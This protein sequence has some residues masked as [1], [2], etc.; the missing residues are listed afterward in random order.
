MTT[1]VKAAPRGAG[2]GLAKLRVLVIL[3]DPAALGEPAIR[4]EIAALEAGHEVAV[5]TRSA[6]APKADPDTEFARVLAE[7]AAFAPEVLHAHGLGQSGFVTRLAAAADLPFTLRAHARDCAPLRPPR[8]GER[9]L[10][11]LRR[12]PAPPPSQDLAAALRATADERC[13]GLLALPFARPWLLRAGVVEGKLVDC[14]PALDFAAFHDLS[15]NGEAVMHIGAGGGSKPVPDILRLAAKVP[16]RSFTHYGEVNA[17]RAMQLAA[18]LAIAGPVAPEAMPAEYKKHRWLVHT[19]D[20]DSA[21]HDWPL[22]IAEAQAAGVGVCLPNS[23][24][25]LLRFVGEGAGILY[26]TIDEL[27]AIVSGPLPEEMRERG[28]AQARKSDIA[29]HLPLLTDLWADALAGRAPRPEPVQAAAVPES[30][31]P[32]PLPSPAPGLA[33]TA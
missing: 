26:E 4:T 3:P 10:R 27:P 24:P 2:P 7:V 21:V 11:L 19:G 22:A 31:A 15:P 33:S 18:G 8:M 25:D 17:A 6:P 12:V 28:F 32:R 16:G 1:I 9:M 5:L 13:L 14:F 30:A 23:R 29:A 20:A